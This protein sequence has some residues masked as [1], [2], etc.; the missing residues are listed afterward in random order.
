MSK[1]GEPPLDLA[2]VGEPAVAEFGEAVARAE[3]VVDDVEDDADPVAMRRVNES[4]ALVVGR[5]VDAPS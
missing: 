3:V 4:C 5:A 2:A 1:F